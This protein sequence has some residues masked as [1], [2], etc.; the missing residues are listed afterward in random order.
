MSKPDNQQF[1]QDPTL[2]AIAIAYRNPKEALIADE[3]LPKVP[4]PEEDFKWQRYEDGEDFSVPDT[5]VGRRSAPNQVEIQGKELTSSTEDYGIDIPLDKKTIKQAEKKGWDPRKRAT[6]RATDIVMLDREVNVAKLVTDPDQYHD[7]NKATL[8]A[9]QAINN[10]ASDP[11][12]L[13]LEMLDACL[14]MPSQLVFGTAVWR[15]FRQHPRV[16]KS[17]H[18]ND[19]DEGIVSRSQ[20]AELLEIEQVLV[21]KSRLNIAKP[22]KAPVLKRAWP[23]DI[24]SAQY[25]NPVADTTGGVTFGFTA[26]DGDKI[27]GTKQA[28]IGLYGGE[29]VRSGE[30][31]KELIVANRAGFLIDNAL[32]YV[33]GA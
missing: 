17:I 22:G 15:L 26:M 21:G 23:E 2:T 9:A 27:A 29:F 4:V 10:P 31:R 28:D 7:D 20:V 13:I 5:R 1:Q 32:G 30:S 12:K 25:I 11:I 8:T 16:V 14:M 19:G 18:K 3:V 6:M 24:I 33:E